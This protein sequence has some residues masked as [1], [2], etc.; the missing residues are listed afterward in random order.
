M[1]SQTN[2]NYM[3]C[4]DANCVWYKS[5]QLAVMWIVTFKSHNYN[6]GR[7]EPWL[8]SWLLK[9]FLYGNANTCSYSTYSTKQ[10]ATSPIKMD[11]KMTMTRPKTITNNELKLW[12]DD[13][14][15]PVQKSKSKILNF[16]LVKTKFGQ[17]DK[18][19]KVNWAF[20]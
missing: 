16:I 13:T 3:M 12:P 17:N 4:Y 19:L 8:Y 20:D 10:I 11:L 14:K 5:V 1:W 18:T 15:W 7:F 6:N 9:M 2:K